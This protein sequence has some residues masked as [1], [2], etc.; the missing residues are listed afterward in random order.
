M[1]GA[2]RC[3]KEVVLAHL[4]KLARLEHADVLRD[5][6][7]GFNEV[8]QCWVAPDLEPRGVEREAVACEGY[9]LGVRRTARAIGAM[10]GNDGGVE[11]DGVRQVLG[12][13]ADKAEYDGIRR[14]QR[15]QRPR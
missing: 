10:F 13:A 1:S 7:G 5:G 15:S 6:E 14:G 2:R 8:F 3:H 11:E 12:P 9:C 4:E